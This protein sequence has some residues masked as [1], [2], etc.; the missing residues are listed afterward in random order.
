MHGILFFAAALT[1]THKGVRRLD[2]ARKYSR[3]DYFSPLGRLWV[4][5]ATS[6]ALS[7]L[8]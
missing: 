8:S 4:T 7:T 6:S 3:R 2:Y 1:E 5:R